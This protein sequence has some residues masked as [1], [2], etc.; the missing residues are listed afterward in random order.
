MHHNMARPCENCPLRNDR[1]GYLQV[2]RVQEIAESLGRGGSFPCHK[3]VD[4][5]AA[6]D[7]GD[8]EWCPTGEESQCA[9]AEI[10]LAHQ[11]T[12]TQ[13][14]RIAGRLGVPVAELDMEAPVFKSTDEMMA[15]QPDYE[16]PG[17]TCSVVGPS[18]V[19]PAGYMVG[20]VVTS[21][22][23]YIDTYCTEC[24]EPVCEEC[25][26]EDGMCLN[27]AEWDE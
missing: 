1:P 3:T 6:D 20:G 26:A 17:E 14:S 4:Y 25:F 18:C 13:M 15:A 12:S 23:D 10:F 7:W 9:G 2:N 24:G 5:D 16:E 19:A 21:G 22:T 27:C 11:G 8:E